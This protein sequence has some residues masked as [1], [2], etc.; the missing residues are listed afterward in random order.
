MKLLNLLSQL[1]DLVYRQACRA[2]IER[3]HV[4]AG[5]FDYDEAVSTAF[6]NR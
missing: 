3:C 1:T 2:C 4:V 5:R 6:F